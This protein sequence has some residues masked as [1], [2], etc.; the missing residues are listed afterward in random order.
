MKERRR[1]KKIEI[2]ASIVL[3]SIFV[4]KIK[5]ILNIMVNFFC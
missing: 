1:R 5:K 4:N 3:R 2:I